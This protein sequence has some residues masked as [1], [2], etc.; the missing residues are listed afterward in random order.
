VS[1]DVRLLLKAILFVCLSVC[2]TCDS[3]YQNTFYTIRQ[4]NVS[5]FLRPNFVV[6][7][8]GFTLRVHL[9]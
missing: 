7:S 5:S 9:K 8:W 4:S 3:R 1:N 6:T 2:H